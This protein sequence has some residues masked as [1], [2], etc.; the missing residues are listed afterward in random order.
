LKSL[1]YMSALSD[2]DEGHSNL[3]GDQKTGGAVEAPTAITQSLQ[4]GDDYR[5]RTVW[6]PRPLPPPYCP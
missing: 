1:F 3:A 4:P 2:K 5:P 6:W